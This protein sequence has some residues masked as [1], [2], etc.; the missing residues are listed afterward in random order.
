V[1]AITIIEDHALLAESLVLALRQHEV[2]A[3]ALPIQPAPE[4]LAAAVASHPD[5]VLLDLDLAGSG[6]GTSLVAPL[7]KA[8]VSTL[9]VTGITDR[10]RIAAALEQGAFGYQPKA[11]GLD[12]LL[13]AT[14]RALEGSA[15]PD[16]A[17]RHALLAELAQHRA[18][19]AR[20]ERLRK[21]LTAREEAT[22]HALGEGRHVREIA[23]QW[24][25]SEA[26]V[27]TY[28][29][30]VLTKLGAGSQLAAVAVAR[31]HGWL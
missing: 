10:L 13:A 31:R 20:D 15:A 12:S 7:R 30:G 16:E 11:A 23:A 1:P 5:L 27:R 22:L 17:E 4:L 3:Q 26:T 8:G 19:G 28:V 24:V 21:Q 18:R 6:D 2:Q 14:L 29:R 25:V 9:V